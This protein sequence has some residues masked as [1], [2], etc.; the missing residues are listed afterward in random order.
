MEKGILKIA[1]KIRP[2]AEKMPQRH[3]FGLIFV[4]I[5][6][7][8]SE[9]IFGHNGVKI[10]GSV[11][12]CIKIKKVHLKWKPKIAFYPLKLHFFI[13]GFSR[14]SYKKSRRKA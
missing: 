12:F 6:F 3:F 5:C 2:W 4:K 7:Y 11:Y 1:Q 9:V 14:S 8:N 10:G 13:L